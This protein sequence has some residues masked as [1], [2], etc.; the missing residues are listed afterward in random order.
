[1]REELCH[2]AIRLGLLL[3][4]LMPDD[5][6]VWGL[7][8]LM[9]LHD[10]RRLARVDMDGRYLAIGD[11]DRSRWDQTRIREGHRALE[12]SVRLGRPGQYQL[13]A[14]ITALQMESEPD[15]PQI[16]DLYG[17]L[18]KLTPTPV[19]KLNCAVAVGFAHGPQAGLDLLAPLLEDPTLSHYQ[20]LHAAL[21]ELLK[22]LGD[23]EGASHAYQMAIEL[24]GNAVERAELERRLRAL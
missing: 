5:A 9:L 13:Q 22:R 24:S 18:V 19:V 15:W 11:Q 12:R 7:F 23:R 4:E 14:A 1:V 16:A 6:E 21:A 10:S 3:R 2:E 8:A 17:A 20:P